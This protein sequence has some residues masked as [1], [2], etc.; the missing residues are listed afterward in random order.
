MEKNGGKKNLTCQ[1]GQSVFPTLFHTLGTFKTCV[2]GDN[3]MFKETQLDYSIDV[4]LR[5]QNDT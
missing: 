3:M 1:S 4:T 2:K 5:E